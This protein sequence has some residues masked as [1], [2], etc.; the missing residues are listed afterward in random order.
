MSFKC[1]LYFNL[2]VLVQLMVKVLLQNFRDCQKKH[3]LGSHMLRNHISSHL[4]VNR[5]V[6]VLG[7]MTLMKYFSISND[8]KLVNYRLAR[9]AYFTVVHLI[10]CESPDTVPLYL[11]IWESD[12]S[13]NFVAQQKLVYSFSSL[14]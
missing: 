4:C 10:A 5:D 14:F 3:V 8:G 2:S 12:R 6:C 11:H 13:R 7:L 1:T 9:Y